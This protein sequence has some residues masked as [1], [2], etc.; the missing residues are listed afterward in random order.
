VSEATLTWRWFRFVW[1]GQGAD[2]ARLLVGSALTAA[3]HAGFAWMWKVVV[4]AARDGHVGRAALVCLGVGV[5]QALLY[6][7]VQGTRTR[8]NERIQQA[9]LRQRGTS[10]SAS[11]PRA[12]PSRARPARPRRRLVGRTVCGCAGS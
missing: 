3:M 12:K 11:Q 7:A 10:I 4:D 5:G 2:M 1:R 9:A 8:V 6:V